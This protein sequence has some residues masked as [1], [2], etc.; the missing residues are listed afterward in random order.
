MWR[1][2]KMKEA[3]TGPPPYTEDKDIPSYNFVV[4]PQFH[5]LHFRLIKVHPR[6]KEAIEPGWQKA[7]NYS[8]NDPEIINWTK[9]G[10]N[11]GITCPSGF[12][13]FVDADSVEI[14]T[15]LDSKLPLTFRW[16]TGKPG[17][18]QFAY[19]VEDGPL[20]CVPLRGGAY[21]K[22]RGGYALGPGSVHPNGVVYGSREIRN[23]PVATVTKAQLVDALSEFLVTPNKPNK[24]REGGGA[25]KARILRKKEVRADQV[26]ELISELTSTWAR[27]DHLRHVLT[28]SIIGTCEKGKWDQKSVE[29]VVEGLITGT[30][31]GQEHLVQVKHAWG[32]NGKRYGIPTL[33]KIMEAVRND[34]N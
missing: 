25:T 31:V 16:S 22:G 8:W 11:F 9:K 2:I 10:G 14:Q 30:G 12:C 6:R 18:Y 19:F 29:S 5:D 1:A 34:R 27:A 33:K 32:K 15:A 24:Q 23:V 7:Q 28:L 26:E 21:I 17:H 3:R 20:G 4:P 13:A